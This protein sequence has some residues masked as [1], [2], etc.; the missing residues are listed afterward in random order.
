MPEIRGARSASIAASDIR[1][2]FIAASAASALVAWS[3]ISL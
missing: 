3:I 2:L 1:A